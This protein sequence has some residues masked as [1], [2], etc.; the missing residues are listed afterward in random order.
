MLVWCGGL[1]S[2]IGDSMLRLTLPFYIYARTG[3]VLATTAMF[4]ASS[5]PGLLLGSVAGVFVDRWDRRR[6]MIAADVG[7]A[8]LI[9][10]LLTVQSQGG[11]W[12]VY[13][14]GFLESAL[15]LFFGPAKAALIPALVGEQQLVAA[16]S[17][18]GVSNG[19]VGVLGPSL[20]GALLGLLG[21]PGLVL[22]DSLS[23]LISALLIALIPAPS[24]EPGAVAR[25]AGPARPPAM[26]ATPPRAALWGEWRDG[27]RVVSHDRRILMLLVFA[28]IATFGDGL[29]VAVIVPYV[30]NVVGASVAQFGWIASVEAASAVLGGLAL[31][32]FGPRVSPIQLMGLGLVLGSAAYASEALFPSLQFLLGL[33]AL[34]GAT[35]VA[36]QA[37]YNTL[38]QSSGPDRVRGRVFGIAGM[39]T[40]VMVLGGMGLGGMLGGLLGIRPILAV[41]G[42]CNAWAGILTLVLL[43]RSAPLATTTPVGIAQDLASGAEDASRTAT[44]PL[45]P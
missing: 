39:A 23:Y 34:V 41:A 26:P 17:L 12:P 27:A 22:A 16:N 32:A 19:L 30:K 4:I 43:P 2:G 1:V 13:G 10:L 28:G 45:R 33:A 15:S 44:C 37:G 11:L 40:A 18:T 21:L 25:T 5:T 9:V 24:E 8:G 36:M 6:T 38:L 42:A 7:R 20:G 3:S 29:G 14:V 35:V 31:G